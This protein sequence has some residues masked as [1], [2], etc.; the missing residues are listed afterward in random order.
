MKRENTTRTGYFANTKTY[1]QVHLVNEYTKPICGSR[2]GKKEFQFNAMG[3]EY[4]YIECAK[5][6]KLAKKLLQNEDKH[7]LK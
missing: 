4:G 3:I 7:L 6:K 2:I 1:T 5:C